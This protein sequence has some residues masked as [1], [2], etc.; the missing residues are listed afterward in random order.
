MEVHLTDE[1]VRRFVTAM[2]PLLLLNMYSKNLSLR[3]ETLF[4]LKSLAELA[5][6]LIVPELLNRLYPALDSLTEPHRLTASMSAVTICLRS[7][8]HVEQGK[9]YFLSFYSTLFL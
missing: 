5:P 1:R 3:L 7:L 8:F 2:K 9:V 6:D 4:A